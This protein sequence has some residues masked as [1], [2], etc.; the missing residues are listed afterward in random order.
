MEA[1][2]V[3]RWGLVPG[4][5]AILQVWRTV[6]E[7]HYDALVDVF[8]ADSA[9]VS[10]ALHETL[11]SPFAP[12]VSAPVTLSPQ[13]SSTSLPAL[14]PGSTSLPALQLA[15]TPVPVAVTH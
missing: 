14:Q 13:P 1:L 2:D 15:S 7:V 3:Y 4:T 9:E 8:G 10:R 5:P 12:P 11:I 6:R